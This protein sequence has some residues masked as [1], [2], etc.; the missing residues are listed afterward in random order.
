MSKTSDTRQLTF[1]APVNI[2]MMPDGAIMARPGRPVARMNTRQ[3][4]REF[5]VDRSTVCRWIEDG[6]IPEDHVSK[7]GK[8]RYLI[9]AAAVE[10]LRQHWTS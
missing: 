6:T 2:T 8:R 4:A 10:L 1:W 5:G 7:G 3:F 9:D